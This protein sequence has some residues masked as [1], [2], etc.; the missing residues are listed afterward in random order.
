MADRYGDSHPDVAAAIV[1]L[2]EFQRETE[3][4]SW[5]LD[6]SMK[7]SPP[8]APPELSGMTAGLQSLLAT[9]T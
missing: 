1:A 3:S 5:R 6:Q 8:A 7:L 4:P 9:E 2:A